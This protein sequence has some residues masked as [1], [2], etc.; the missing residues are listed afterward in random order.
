MLQRRLSRLDEQG[1]SAC[2]TP[3]ILPYFAGVL[4]EFRLFYIN[5]KIKTQYH[6]TL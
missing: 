6:V 5:L 2:I 3:Y 1:L 4:P